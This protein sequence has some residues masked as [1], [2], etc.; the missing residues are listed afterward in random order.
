MAVSVVTG[1]DIDGIKSIRDINW[2][3]LSEAS[4]AL[5][6]ASKMVGNNRLAAIAG[7]TSLFTSLV[8]SSLDNYNDKKNG[9]LTSES[10][11]DVTSTFVT[12]LVTKRLPSDKIGIGAKIVINSI[13]L[14]IDLSSD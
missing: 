12:E 3:D 6:I 14:G 10:F 5:S 1:I 13:N 9:T 11:A 8:S 4:A 2:D 7:S